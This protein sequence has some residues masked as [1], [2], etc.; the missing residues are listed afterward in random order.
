[1][2]DDDSGLTYDR[3]LLLGARASSL[4]SGVFRHGLS[5]SWLMIVSSDWKA[6]G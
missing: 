6:W 5:G 3:Q 2:T 4:A 1:M